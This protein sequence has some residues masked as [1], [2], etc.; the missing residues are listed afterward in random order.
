MNWYATIHDATI[1]FHG[2]QFGNKMRYPIHR[3]EGDVVVVKVPGHSRWGDLL[4]PSVYAP[5]QF[6][7]LRL[8]KEHDYGRRAIELIISF[9]LKPSGSG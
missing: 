4:H 2:V 3:R 9:D 8:G 6:H 7:V 1:E 5:A